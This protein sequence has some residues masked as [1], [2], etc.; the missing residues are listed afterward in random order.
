MPIKAIKRI[1]DDQDMGIGIKLTLLDGSELNIP[2]ETLR[3]ECPCASCLDSKGK[4]SHDKP[5][6]GRA[7]LRVIK[8]T[9]EESLGIQNIWALGNYAI[10]MKWSDGHDTGIYT[11][12]NLESLGAAESTTKTQ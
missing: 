1:T 11:Y 6:G 7:S 2:S 8:A 5:L 9:K 12:T 10:G 4:L 3:K